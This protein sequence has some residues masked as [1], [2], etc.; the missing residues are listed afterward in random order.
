MPPAPAGA[1][2]ALRDATADI[3][4]RL[5]AVP[6]FQALADG[7]L[8]EAGYVALLRRM[9]GFHMA[10]EASLAVAPPLAAYGVDLAERRRTGLLQ[11]DLRHFQAP[12]A[13][14]PAPVPLLATAARALGALYVTEG[15]TLGGRQLAHGLDHLLPPGTMEG[16]AFLLGHGARHGA[17]WLACCTAIETC[18]RETG[19]LVGMQSGAVETFAAFEAWFG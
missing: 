13:A 18:G 3:H 17:M 2:F 9:L 6:A 11:A 5:H 14:P 19:G 4:A 15:S 8:D 12:E 7:R 10:I 16:R 1:R